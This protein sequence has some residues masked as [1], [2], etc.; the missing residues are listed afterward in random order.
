MHQL[1]L[2]GVT[3]DDFI[4]RDFFRAS[5]GPSETRFETGEPSHQYE[6]HET[7]SVPV[8][9]TYQR[10]AIHLFAVA[11]QVLSPPGV[12][13]ASLP[14]STL[15][16]QDRGKEPMHDEGPSGERETDFILLHGHDTDTDPQSA[17]LKEII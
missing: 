17:Q 15:Q 1:D 4:S 10:G 11:K 2:Q 3:W 14:T 12:E 7:T 5:Q 9:V 6:H 8:F 16:V 13:G